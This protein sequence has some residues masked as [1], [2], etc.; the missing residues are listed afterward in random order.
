MYSSY[1]LGDTGCHSE[2]CWLS[3][4]DVL[5]AHL[6]GASL[7][8]WGAICGAQTLRS[9]GRRLEWRVP[10]QLWVTALEVGFMAR[11]CLNLSYLF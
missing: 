7:K 10:S 9:S 2:S 3:K 4:A 11:L 8:S 5:G 6:L 1:F